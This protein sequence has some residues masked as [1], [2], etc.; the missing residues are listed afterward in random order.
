MEENGLPRGVLGH[1]VLNSENRLIATL[2]LAWPKGVKEGI[3]QQAALLLDESPDILQIANAN[4]FRYFTDLNQLKDY[5]RGE[6]IG[7]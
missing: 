3:T 7:E 6:I 4:G 5:V 2:D 1:E